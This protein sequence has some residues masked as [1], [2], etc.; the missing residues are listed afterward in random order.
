MYFLTSPIE[1]EA[2]FG[3]CLF[4]KLVIFSKSIVMKNVTIIV[5]IVFTKIPGIDVAKPET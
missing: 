1:F 4:I 2:D 3:S 5:I